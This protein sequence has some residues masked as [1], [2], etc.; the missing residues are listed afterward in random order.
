MFIAFTIG[1]VAIHC[2]GRAGS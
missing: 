1:G 2:I